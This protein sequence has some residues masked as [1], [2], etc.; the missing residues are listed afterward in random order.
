MAELSALADGSLEPARRPEVEARIADSEELRRRFEHERMAV[1]ALA[2]AR[3]Q[4]RAPEHLRSKIEA[5]RRPDRRLARAGWTGAR[6]RWTGARART[7]L[8]AALAA[9]GLILALALPGGT[10]G[11]PTVSQAAS[12]A[13]RGPSLP[14]PAIDSANPARLQAS[15]GSLHFPN[16]GT[17]F[18]ERATGM[19]GD[20]L[21][22]RQVVTVYYAIAGRTVAYSIVSGSFLAASDASRHG[23]RYIEALRVG[24]RNVVTW[25]EAGHTCV[26]SAAGLPGP[27][28]AA[29]VAHA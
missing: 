14:A 1:S 28:L 25:R 29:L 9:I 26:L 19:R 3:E 20:R 15:V 7:G 22:G 6:A 10:P 11:G 8:V 12:L 24:G 21:G 23:S 2:A 18:G 13:T 4:D 16:W 17:R 27:A 5:L